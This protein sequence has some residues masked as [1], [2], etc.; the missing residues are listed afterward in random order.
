M[1]WQSSPG[2]TS[3]WAASAGKS[4]GDLPDVQ[5]VDLDDAG[6]PASARPTAS[7]S[8]PAGAPSSRTRPESRSRLQAV[9]SISARDEQ[10]GDR[11]G[12]AEAEQQDER[13]GERGAERRVEVG[14]HVRA[15]ALDVE[16]AALGAAPAPT[17]PRR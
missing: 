5:V 10:R 12:R 11:V 6:W 13:A 14:Q 9:R 1:R 15:G 2:A 3:T 8:M 17:P 16:R 7:G 4:G